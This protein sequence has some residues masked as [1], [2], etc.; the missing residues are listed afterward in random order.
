[1]IKMLVQSQNEE[2]HEHWG[3]LKR[4]HVFFDNR[5]PDRISMYFLNVFQTGR[6]F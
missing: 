2:K 1:M 6:L 4:V 3:S 5:H